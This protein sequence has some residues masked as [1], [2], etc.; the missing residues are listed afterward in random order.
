MMTKAIEAH[1]ALHGE[2][3]KDPAKASSE[4]QRIELDLIAPILEAAVK[5]LENNHL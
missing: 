4:K 5:L 2:R 3:E 1:A